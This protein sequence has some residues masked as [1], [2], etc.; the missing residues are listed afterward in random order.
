MPQQVWSPKA[1]LKR[2][3]DVEEEMA[4]LESVVEYVFVIFLFY[5]L[6]YIYIF[7]KYKIFK[8]LNIHLKF[9]I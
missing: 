9:G 8:Y 4:E 6:L 1:S 2:L 5:I 3:R 7:L